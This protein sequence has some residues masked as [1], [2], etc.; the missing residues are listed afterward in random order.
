MS[1]KPIRP[2]LEKCPQCLALPGVKCTEQGFVLESVHMSRY[3][4]ASIRQTP[5]PRTPDI[6]VLLVKCPRCGAMPRRTCAGP[7][8]MRD[9][10]PYHKE[11]WLEKFKLDNAGR[12]ALG[13]EPRPL[14]DFGKPWLENRD[15]PQ[16]KTVGWRDLQ[17][18]R[19]QREAMKQE[20]DND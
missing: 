11:R 12:K 19:E 2:L 16:R 7:P 15:T 3:S 13:L 8:P 4:I 10:K 18:A 14:E 20:D 6:S 5:A 17:E 1:K 9:P